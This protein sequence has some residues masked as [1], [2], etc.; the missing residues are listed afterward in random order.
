M[1]TAEYETEYTYAVCPILEDA[2]LDAMTDT[3]LLEERSNW[4]MSLSDDDPMAWDI[5]CNLR[6]CE[7]HLEL[8]GISDEELAKELEQARSA[9]AYWTQRDSDRNAN[10]VVRSLK[11][12]TDDYTR[13]MRRRRRHGDHLMPI[14][15]ILHD[16]S[17]P[18]LS[19]RN[20]PKGRPRCK[21]D[22]THRNVTTHNCFIRSRP[23]AVVREGRSER[24]QSLTGC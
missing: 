6:L 20:P 16:L 12:D 21:Q 7:R 2:D 5:D 22:R 15:T 4:T 17:Q 18:T 13:E 10:R 1:K 24:P 14:S 3:E 23:K 9:I 19:C 11:A 8:R